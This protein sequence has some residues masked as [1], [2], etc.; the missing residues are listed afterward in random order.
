MRVPH[1]VV[2]TLQRRAATPLMHA[3][4]LQQLRAELEATL[5]RIRTA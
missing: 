4:G 2:K 3:G 1:S 5:A